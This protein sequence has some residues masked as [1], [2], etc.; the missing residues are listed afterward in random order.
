MLRVRDS[1]SNTMS[2]ILVMPYCKVVEH[3]SLSIVIQNIIIT[4]IIIII[5]SSSSS[6]SITI[7]KR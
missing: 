7:N 6:S 2:N 5:S 4:I 3:S 1:I